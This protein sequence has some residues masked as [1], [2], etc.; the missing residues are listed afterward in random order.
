MG[1]TQA[2]SVAED[3]QQLEPLHTGGGHAKW[4]KPV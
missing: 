3:M 4:N 2:I 1:E